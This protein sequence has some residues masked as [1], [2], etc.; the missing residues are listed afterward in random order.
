M[1]KLKNIWQH[2]ATDDH[3]AD[4][5]TRGV[6]VK[7][8]Q[9]DARLFY[10]LADTDDDHTRA[11]DAY[12]AM[13]DWGEDDTVHLSSWAGVAGLACDHE[14]DE[15]DIYIGDPTETSTHRRAV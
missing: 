11:V 5:G 3:G 15:A 1:S 7:D 2:D 8:E 9:G 4:T 6:W 14:D 12:L 10:P 13:G